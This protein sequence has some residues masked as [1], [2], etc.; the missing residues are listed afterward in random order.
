MTYPP[1][2]GT[3]RAPYQMLALVI[4]AV[5]LLIGQENGGRTRHAP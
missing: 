3:R 5:Y 4:G 2:V 1:S